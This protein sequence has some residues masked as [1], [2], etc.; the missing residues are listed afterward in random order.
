MKAA[1]DHLGHRF[2]YIHD[3]FEAVIYVHRPCHTSTKS[4]LGFEGQVSVCAVR[5]V[6]SVAVPLH[7]HE[8]Q[9]S[10]LSLVSRVEREW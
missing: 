8:H 5:G 9:E 7:R 4:N 3:I 6:V 10:R 1:R 2:S